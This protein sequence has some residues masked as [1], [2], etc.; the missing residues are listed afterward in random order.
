MHAL[1][2]TWE[3]ERYGE[4]D[5]KEVRG[6]YKITNGLTLDDYDRLRSLLCHYIAQLQAT[7]KAP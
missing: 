5:V 2:G 1:P 7:Q 4:D 6:D 3:E